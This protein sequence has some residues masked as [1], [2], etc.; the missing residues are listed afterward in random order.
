MRAGTTSNALEDA[1]RL[2]PG[3]LQAAPVQAKD[4]VSGSGRAASQAGQWLQ[5]RQ[6]PAIGRQVVP[7][8]ARGL[9]EA[10]TRAGLDRKMAHHFRDW[11]G[12]EGGC[13][14]GQGVSWSPDPLEE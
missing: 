9:G 3:L 8:P 6:T 4:R 7:L 10:R 2:V 1:A 12:R 13:E 14:R 11:R 5:E